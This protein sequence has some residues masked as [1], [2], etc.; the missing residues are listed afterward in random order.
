MVTVDGIDVRDWPLD[1]LRREVGVVPQL[2]F[3]FSASVR[4]NIRLGTTETVD[5]DAVAAAATAAGLDPD[6]AEWPDGL[7]T[8]VGERGVAVSGGQRQRIAIARALVADPPI[9]LLDDCLSSLDA[10]T[11]ESILARLREARQGR[12]RTTMLATHRLAEA[13]RCDRIVVL[14][15][16]RVVQSGTHAELATRPGLYAR[17]VERQRLEAEIEGEI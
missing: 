6:L 9:L 4:E 16:G 3:L 10:E 13:A 15:R 8:V 7:D 2:P 14:D 12:P 17:L 5:D 1:R 11:A